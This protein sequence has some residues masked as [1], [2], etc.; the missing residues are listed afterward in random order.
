LRPVLIGRDPLATELLYDQMIRMD[1]HGR[2]GMFMTAASA[3]DNA[4]WA[5]KG[6]AWGQPIYRLLGGPTRPAVPAYASMLGFSVQPE[7][8]AAVAAEYKAMGYRAQKWFFRYG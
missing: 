6:K 5:L 3:V 8:A 4:L 2:S 7:E 1:R